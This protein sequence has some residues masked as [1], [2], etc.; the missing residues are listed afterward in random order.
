M[1]E[2]PRGKLPISRLEV[3]LVQRRC[4]QFWMSIKLVVSRGSLER[5]HCHYSYLKKIL[6]LSFPIASYAI[7]S[8]KMLQSA[9]SSSMSSGI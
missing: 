3:P 4:L 7:C 9:Q 6:P 5:P 8:S 1:E 2:V